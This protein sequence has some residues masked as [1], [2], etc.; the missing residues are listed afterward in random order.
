MKT[1]KSFLV[2][3]H[4]FRSAVIIITIIIIIAFLFFYTF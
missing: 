4:C 1:K 3:N 2:D